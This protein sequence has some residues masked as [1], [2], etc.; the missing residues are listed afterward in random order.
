MF[1]KFIRFLDRHFEEVLCSAMIGYIAVALNI[2]VFNR[3]VL[4]SPSAY[5]DEIVRMLMLFIVF[6]G[7]PWAVKQDRH[8]VIDLWPQDLSPDRKFILDLISNGLFLIFSIVFLSAAMEAVEFHKMLE[9]RTEA[10]GFEYWIQL[11]I[12]P[13]SFFL[14]CIRL[15]QKIYQSWIEFRT[16]NE[17]H[18]MAS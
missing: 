3:Y 2:E 13:F 12:L 10:L 5:T 9:S 14:T 1:I 15:I 17:K 4:F 11:S 18:E 8:I 7:V 6:L 16:S